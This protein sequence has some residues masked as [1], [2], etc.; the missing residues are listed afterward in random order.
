MART[1]APVPVYSADSP[2]HPNAGTGIRAKISCMPDPRDTPTLR[3]DKWLW[4]ARF[5]KTRELA[6]SACDIGRIE[7][8]GQRAKP[9]R[10]LRAG[11]R[12]RIRNEAGEFE[13]EV[14]LLSP[15][16]GPAAAAQALFQESDESRTR[17][18]AQAA[19]RKA[20]NPANMAPASRPSK[21]DRQ[22]LDRLRGRG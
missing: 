17:R 22:S 19:E 18:A 11:D 12:L 21:H 2:L 15:V 3:L 13:G 5:F 8:N 6:A 14:L 1:A 4:A 9:S 20:L 10:I 16:R 7:A